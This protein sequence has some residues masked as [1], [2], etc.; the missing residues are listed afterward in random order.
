MGDLFLR[1]K[2]YLPFGI[3][4]VLYF[5][6]RHRALGYG[7]T[8]DLHLG[9]VWFRVITAPSIV[10]DYFRLQIFPYPLEL[11]HGSPKIFGFERL[12]MVWGVLFMGLYFFVLFKIG[13][14]PRR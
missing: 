13:D 2:T 11:Y 14:I 12:A 8:Q 9:D 5:I 7:L 1:W 3:I 4:L 6:A 10:W